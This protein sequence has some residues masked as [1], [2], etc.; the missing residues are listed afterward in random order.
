M[1]STLCKSGMSSSRLAWRSSRRLKRYRGKHW[2]FDI[3]SRSGIV[4]T[5]ST[6]N[7]LG[8]AH[9]RDADR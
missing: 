2:P 6:E 4:S 7:G 5:A 9:S 1:L 3:S 8:R